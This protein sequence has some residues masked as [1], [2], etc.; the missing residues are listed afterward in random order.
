[1]N[2]TLATKTQVLTKIIALTSLDTYSLDKPSP[3]SS[4][5]SFSCTGSLLASQDGVTDD[6][7]LSDVATIT[8]SE[9]TTSEVV[10]ID[11]DL[12]TG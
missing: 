9:I 11:V 4:T 12:V 6:D 8:I 2:C 5:F 1:M 3:C 7:V 10:M